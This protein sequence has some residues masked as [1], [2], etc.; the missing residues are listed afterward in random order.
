M[1]KRASPAFLALLVSILSWSSIPLFLKYFTDS[2]DAWTVNGVRYAFSALLMLP[3]LR[4]RTAGSEKQR[5]LWSSALVPACVNTAGQVGWALIPYYVTASVMAFGIRA[6]FLFTILGSLWLL[7]EERYLLR[8]RPFWLGAV[9]C[10]AGLSALFWASLRQA[11]ASVPGLLILL[12][13]AAVW[14]FYGITVRKFMKDH[15][16]HRSFAAISLYTSGILTVLM[17]SF[18]R[19]SALARLSPGNLSLLALSSVLGIAL[20]HVLMYYVLNRLGPIVESGAEMLAPFLTFCGAALIFGERLSA[21]QWTGGLG[22]IAGCVL[23][24][25]AHKPRPALAVTTDAL[26]LD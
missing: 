15:Q 25:S 19:V 21:L 7:P 20:A 18:G 11:S 22:V 16:P 2:L 26:G 23:M 14:G 10:I 17:L 9:S 8:S 6:S 5:S 24:V 4:V 12:S 1:K 13:C 3:G